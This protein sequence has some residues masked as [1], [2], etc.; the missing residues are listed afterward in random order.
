M[1]NE[2]TDNELI[3]EFM[4][5]KKQRFDHNYFYDQSWDVLMPVVEKIGQHVYD[6]FEELTNDGGIEVRKDR[7]YP[8]TF[9]MQDVDGRY[10][11]RFNRS[12]LYFGDTLIEAA[13]AAVVDWIKWY[14]LTPS[15]ENV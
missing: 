2:K 14:S 13:Y 8:R 12:T 1:T 15:P 4:G 9:G 5:D 3:A 11:F 7:A 10:M 6:E